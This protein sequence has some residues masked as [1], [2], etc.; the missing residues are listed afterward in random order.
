MRKID[1]AKPASVAATTL[2]AG[3]LLVW[4]WIK[5]QQGFVL[6]VASGFQGCRGSSALLSLLG[7][8]LPLREASDGAQE[9]F[10]T[11]QPLL[12]RP[13]VR[14][15]SL[16]PVPLPLRWIRSLLEGRHEGRAVRAS[17]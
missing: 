1:V 10:V 13:G 7:P 12:L 4:F 9:P 15:A 17:T 2:F 6:E 5:I 14:L 16:C 8:H 11:R 3:L